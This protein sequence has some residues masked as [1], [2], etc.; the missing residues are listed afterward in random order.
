MA[1]LKY[2]TFDSLVLMGIKKYGGKGG[3][4]EIANRTRFF[5]SSLVVHLKRFSPNNLVLKLVRWSLMGRS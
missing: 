5:S 3:G 2:L 1:L 4:E